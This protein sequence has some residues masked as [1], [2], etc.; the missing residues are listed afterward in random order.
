MIFHSVEIFLGTRMPTILGS[1]CAFEWRTCENFLRLS[2]PPSLIR[3][4]FLRRDFDFPPTDRRTNR[5]I[6]R[7]ITR[8]GINGGFVIAF[9]ILLIYTSRGF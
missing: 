8:R 1:A 7:A 2:R 6:T 3:V 5:F 4:S 9:P